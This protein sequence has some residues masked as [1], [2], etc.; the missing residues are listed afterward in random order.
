ML[1]ANTNT[2]M[3]VFFNY[4]TLSQYKAHTDY[5][6]ITFNNEVASMQIKK[7]IWFGVNRSYEMK[8]TH[9]HFFVKLERTI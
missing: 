2:V 7:W 9:C 4:Y 3:F 1:L 6:M 5:R 8:F